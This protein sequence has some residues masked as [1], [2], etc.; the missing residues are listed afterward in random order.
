MYSLK[1][2]TLTTT[3]CLIPNFS[4][5]QRFPYSKILIKKMIIR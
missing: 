3:L 1:L 4:M 5:E 2:I